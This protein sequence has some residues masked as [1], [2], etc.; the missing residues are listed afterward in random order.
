MTPDEQFI[1]CVENFSRESVSILDRKNAY[2]KVTPLI[3]NYCTVDTENGTYEILEKYQDN[4]E[5]KN[6]VATYFAFDINS[7]I[8]EAKATNLMS[9]ADLVHKLGTQ[10]RSADSIKA[11]NEIVAEINSFTKINLNLID[12][13]SDNLTVN[14]DG[15]YTEEPN[16]AVD[17]DEL[18]IIYNR[19]VKQIDYDTN[20]ATFVG[21][22]QR[23]QRATSASATQR[24]YNYA[25]D[26]VDNDL[27]DLNLILLDDAPY[28]ENFMDLVEAYNVY[29]NSQ[30]KLD[31]VTK[32]GNS[33]RIVQCVNAIDIYR[34][35]EQW[36][37]NREIIIEY[38][39]IVKDY[40][41]GTD[42][43][44]DPLYDKSYDGI[45]E[46]IRFF[47]RVYS[48]FYT[49]MQDEHDEYIGYLLDL[50]AATD[51]YV[52]K[53]GLVAL[54]DRYVDTN[55]VNVDDPRI[56]KHLSNLE[57][58]RSELVL[59][60]E[61]YSKL[62]HQ[63]SV[64]FVNYV[65]K[66]RTAE[67]YA[68][69]VEFYEKASLLYFSLDST[70]EGTLAAIEIYDEYNVKLKR[71]KESSVKFLEAMAIYRACETEEDK[72]AALVE[73]YYNAQFAELSYEGVAEA[74]AEYQAAYDAYVSY[75]NAVN[76]D[77]TAAGNAV[78]SLRV[79][80]GITVIIAIIIKKI[81]GI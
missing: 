5:I 54:V 50:I 74:M 32:T 65:A 1:F 77:L 4:E 64:Y 10:E 76:S 30:K 45:D 71:I 2:D 24:Y 55:E 18:L 40:V 69:Q 61:D 43:N 70:V 53:I 41:Y 7:L 17:Y 13:E 59:R 51:D 3:R 15:S 38:L 67:T 58:C 42:K 12:I 29:L 79:N 34:T 22:I 72:Y 8:A 63:N 62:L 35:E 6:A 33:K 19:V 28:R 52:E 60:G 26:F 31:E 81:F 80:C 56:A 11:R 36:E 39:N 14:P 46:A 68:K 44:G 9:Y 23:F 20:S 25:K 21:Y 78:G 47:D 49:Q 48:Y 37:A 75:A 73:C 27:I 16:G 66:M 57:T